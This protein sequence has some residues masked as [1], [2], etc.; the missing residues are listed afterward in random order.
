MFSRVQ[1]L[2]IFWG[3]TGIGRGISLKGINKTKVFAD[4]K[5]VEILKMQPKK[6]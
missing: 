4:F 1:R 5:F 2:T 3:V 6:L